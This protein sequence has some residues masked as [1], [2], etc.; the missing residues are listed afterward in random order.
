MTQT[1]THTHTSQRR[2]QSSTVYCKCPQKSLCPHKCRFEMR[3]GRTCPFVSG[4][5]SIRCLSSGTR[6][7]WRTRAR[8][9]ASGSR[10]SP[11]AA[12]TRHVA[13]FFNGSDLRESVSRERERETLEKT[14][15]EDL[16]AEPNDR[17]SLER[18]A[19][20]LAPFPRNARQSWTQRI[21]DP[22]T[23]VP[24]YLERVARE[25]EL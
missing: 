21:G 6:W 15:V 20:G 11:S 5:C 9:C 12:P 4:K 24:R 14:R 17:G 23:R 13:F 16:A 8:P 7:L 22:L 18:L 25:N 10:C 19:L 3:R 1:Y 2:R